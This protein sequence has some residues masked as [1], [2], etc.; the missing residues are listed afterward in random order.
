MSDQE[1]PKP[2]AHVYLSEELYQGR[3]AYKAPD[4]ILEPQRESSQA[5]DNYILDGS[6]NKGEGI[7][8]SS[9]PYSGNH[10]L[11][12]ILIASGPGIKKS[13][14]ISD[15]TIVDLAPTIFAY[16]HVPIPAHMEG[17]V[18]STAFYP[19]ILS[20]NKSLET[21]IDIELND[22]SGEFEEQEENIVEA[23]LRNLGYLD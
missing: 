4:L 12:G 2:L 3:Y 15:A 5:A 13:T 9:L 22:K 19:G 17:K 6:I 23:R 21:I 8:S 16:L 7:L 11:Q 14:E 20:E 18:L 1:R 10:A